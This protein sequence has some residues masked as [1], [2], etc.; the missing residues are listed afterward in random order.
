M[1]GIK[2]RTNPFDEGVETVEVEDVKNVSGQV[3]DRG[4]E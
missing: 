4:M 2:F 3:V 1:W